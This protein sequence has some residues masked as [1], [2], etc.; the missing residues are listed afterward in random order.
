M[1]NLKN[2]INDFLPGN[3]FLTKSMEMY[4]EKSSGTLWYMKKFLVLYYY[5]FLN[6][7]LENPQW[8]QQ[9]CNLFDN[10]IESLPVV[11]RA[12]AI[13]FFYATQDIANLK[14]PHFKSFYKFTGEIEETSS[15]NHYQFIE[16]SKKYYFAFLME[17]GGQSGCNAEI[18]KHLYTHNFKMAQLDSLL[19]HYNRR[20]HI[21]HN[22]TQQKND[23]MASLRN[24]RQILYYYGY[25]HSKSSGAQDLEFSSLTPIG[26]LAL[27]ANAKEFQLIWEHQKI[28]MVSQPPIVRIQNLENLHVDGLKFN[29]NFTPYLDILLWL[30]RKQTLTSQE[31]QYIL[32]RFTEKN[33]CVPPTDTGLAIQAAIKKISS[34]NRTRDTKPEDFTKELKKYIL[35]ISDNM[36]LDHNTNILGCCSLRKGDIFVSNRD[37]FNKI[38]KIYAFLCKHYKLPHFQSVLKAANSEMQKQYQTKLQ[39]QKYLINPQ[40]KIQWDLYMIHP[41]HIIILGLILLFFQIEKNI[42]LSSVKI[43]DLIRYA[44]ERNNFKFL[45]KD[46]NI[47]KEKFKKEIEKIQ[48]AIQKQ[49]NVNVDYIET[50][51]YSQ[52]INQYQNSSSTDLMTKIEKISKSQQ[53]H[54]GRKRNM[55]LI[56][57]LKAYYY[58]TH[59]TNNM[60]LCE[61]CHQPTFITNSKE[62]YIEFHHLIPF[63]QVDGPDHFLNIYALCPSCHRKLHFIRLS[64]KQLL[65]QQL[66]NNNYLQK[67]I[68]VRL[69]ELYMQKKLKSYHLEYLLANNAITQQEY[70]SVL[71]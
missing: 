26:E 50:I 20:H 52:D 14:S 7:F 1:Q 55:I 19:E 59:L 31:Y 58:K 43:A 34:F 21:T 24:E 68:P 40:E 37:K 30:E 15:V 44:W 71:A 64:D 29:I 69:R 39:S 54:I 28:K 9:V 38:L 57:C 62:P 51:P 3:Y 41:D 23:Y 17:T 48:S 13:S 49:I 12:E 33:R 42:P 65:Y 61:C 32:S 5:I 6:D 60:L 56:N 47:T 70:N 66:N 67:T 8:K 35:G 11:L 63:G 10:Y 22:I 4:R 16:L 53:T 18:R 36:S 2:F 45:L 25:V 27:H 46:L